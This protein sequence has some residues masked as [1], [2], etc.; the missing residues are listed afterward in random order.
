MK[1]QI[2]VSTY[3][4][5]LFQNLKQVEQLKQHDHVV[6]DQSPLEK[7]KYPSGLNVF[8][9]EKSLG[10]TKSRNKALEISQGDLVLISDDDLEYTDNFSQK[11]IEAFESNP[12]AAMISFQILKPDGSYF[13]T[14]RDEKFHHTKRTAISTSSVE[15]VFRKKILTERGLKF[16]ELFGVNAKFPCG[17]EAVLVGQILDLGLEALYVPIPICIHPE[18]SSGKDYDRN[19]LLLAKGAMIKRLF[20]PVGFFLLFAFILKNFKK[21]FLSKARITELFKGYFL[22]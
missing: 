21:I 17:E 6:V 8:T 9:L 20:G 13:K 5:R 2:L 11:I 10:L 1:L 19:D 3:Q 15:L 18:E 7:V 22:A 12:N 16:D 14:Y 4:S